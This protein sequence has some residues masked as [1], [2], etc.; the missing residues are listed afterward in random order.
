[1]AWML[2][3]RAGVFVATL[4]V[5]SGVVFGVMAVLPGD[6]AV[7]ALGVNASPELLE[8]TREQMGTDRPLLEQ[9]TS[10]A[11][12]LLRGDFGT[13][14]VT[15]TA[16]GPLVADRML[17]TLWLVGLGVLIAVAVAVPL[18][19]AAAVWHR[20]ARGTVL[21]A[22]SQ[23]GMAVPAFVLAILLVSVFAV[24]LQW[25]E[26]SGWVPPAEDPVEFLRLVALPVLS[27]GLV[28]A[29]LLSR[30]VRSATLDVLREDYLR[31]ARAKGLTPARALWRHGMRNASIPVVTVLGLQ[32]V[33][34]LVD[35]IIIEV[36]FVVP[37]LGSL[38]LESVSNR[39]LLTV[40]GVVM[41]IV[42]AALL[43]NLLIDLMYVLID[44]RLRRAA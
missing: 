26:S 5:A 3:R 8:R 18:G 12:G 29:A 30:Y 15:D 14:Y 22:V 28:Q 27:L 16:I 6:P 7:V 39:D 43:V 32:V 19:V 40:Q 42:A 13:S 33:T 31:T 1:M 23:A 41:V 44:P 9:Y 17:V 24:K 10:W 21:A 38:L 20:K 37:G 34:L 25:V 36:I 2:L 4:V 11:G 35:A